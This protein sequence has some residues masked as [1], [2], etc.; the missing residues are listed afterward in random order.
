MSMCNLNIQKGKF[1]NY[2]LFYENVSSFHSSQA[3]SLAKTLWNWN[4]FSSHHVSLQ[5]TESLEIPNWK[6]DG[7]G[8]EV[9]SANFFFLKTKQSLIPTNTYLY[10][11]DIQLVPTSQKKEVLNKSRWK[12]PMQLVI[13]IRDWHIYCLFFNVKRKFN[14]RFP[15]TYWST[16][17]DQS[18]VIV[19]SIIKD[20]FC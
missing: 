9:I 19:K 1:F 16:L 15:I 12:K 14:K 4:S 20:N 13:K 3:K 7:N 17:S 2:I 5:I 11:L 6:E 8:K 10:S 18:S